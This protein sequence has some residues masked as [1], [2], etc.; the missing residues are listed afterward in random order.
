MRQHIIRSFSALF[1]IA[2]ASLALVQIASARADQHTRRTATT[3]QV[4]AGEYFFRLSTKSIAKP[5]AVTF[6]VRNVGTM[7]HFF[8]IN[9][10]TTSFVAPGKTARLVVAFTKKGNYPYLCTVPGHAALGMKGVFTVR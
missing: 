5:G 9:G 7:S 8:K 1:A 2:F 6:M 10:K 3:I 4:R